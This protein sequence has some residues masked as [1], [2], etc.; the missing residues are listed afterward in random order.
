MVSNDVFRARF[1]DSFDK[2][3]FDDLERS[4]TLVAMLAYQ[5]A[6]DPRPFSRAQR[7]LFPVDPETGKAASWPSCGAPDRSWTEGLRSR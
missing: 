3:S 7:Q 1:R 6:E 5:A 2:I 4:A